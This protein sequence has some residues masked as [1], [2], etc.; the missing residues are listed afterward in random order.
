MTDLKEMADALDALARL[1]GH[2][3][4]PY[5]V[6]ELR[7]RLIASVNEGLREMIRM[8]RLRDPAPEGDAPTPP[9]AAP[10]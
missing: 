8:H 4:D 5:A 10:Q 1:R 6:S 3:V 9:P 7:A 2:D